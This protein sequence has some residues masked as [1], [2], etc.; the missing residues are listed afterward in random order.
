MC[1]SG[2]TEDMQKKNEDG[3]G[4]GEAVMLIMSWDGNEN[5][6]EQDVVERTGIAWAKR[7]SCEC[8]FSF[9]EDVQ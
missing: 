1:G 3:L 9:E 6:Y 2:H 7:A 8:H 4:N 5:E